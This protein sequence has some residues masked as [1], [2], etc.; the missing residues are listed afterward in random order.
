[1]IQF[2]EIVNM[3]GSIRIVTRQS[4]SDVFDDPIEFSINTEINSVEE[5]IT[6][7]KNHLDNGN[8]YSSSG[9]G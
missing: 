1:M 8:L 9:R 3:G 4:G 7:I 6:I 5:L 2:C